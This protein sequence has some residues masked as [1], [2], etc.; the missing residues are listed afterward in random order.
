MFNLQLYIKVISLKLTRTVLQVQQYHNE[1]TQAHF[2]RNI[3]KIDCSPL[4]LEK[5]FLNDKE[6]AHLRSGGIAFPPP[7]PLPFA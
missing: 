1:M 6:E 4:F 7:L 5:I 2:A 3:L